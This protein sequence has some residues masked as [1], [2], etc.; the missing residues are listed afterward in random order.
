MD[1]KKKE[2][3]SNLFGVFLKDSLR[4]EETIGFEHMNTGAASVYSSSAYTLVLSTV[5]DSINFMVFIDSLLKDSQINDNYTRQELINTI[6]EYLGRK[7]KD[8]KIEFGNLLNEITN[9]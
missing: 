4:I 9:H 3:A 8:E 2:K 1:N 6:V 5:Q 7:N